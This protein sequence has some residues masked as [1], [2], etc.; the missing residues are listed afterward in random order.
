MKRKICVVVTA[1]PSY[2]RVKSVLRAIKSHPDIKLQLVVAGSALIN[3]YGNAIKVI[4]DDGFKVDAKV[5]N[6]LEVNNQTAMAKTTSIAI[7]VYRKNDF[8]FYSPL[9]VIHTAP[10]INVSIATVPILTV[11][12]QIDLR[13]SLQA[14]S[15]DLISLISLAAFSSVKPMLSKARLAD[16]SN[17]SSSSS[18]EIFKFDIYYTPSVEIKSTPISGK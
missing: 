7:P 3:R 17:I 10:T 18:G 13:V 9:K 2:S 12:F 14:S 8:I 6:V 4:E 15:K 5:Y 11:V 1:R 16:L